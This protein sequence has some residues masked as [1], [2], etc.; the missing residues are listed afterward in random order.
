MTLT[1]LPKFNTIQEGVDYMSTFLYPCAFQVGTETYDYMG[2]N[3]IIIE[4]IIEIPLNSMNMITGYG[5]FDTTE[6]F[7]YVE[8]GI[9]KC[10]KIK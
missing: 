8:D 10:N 7:L 9:C 2:N 5:N 1:A 4:N 6:G 3:I